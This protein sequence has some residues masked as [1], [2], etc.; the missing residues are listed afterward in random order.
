MVKQNSLARL[1]DGLPSFQEEGSR[2]P[3]ACG[4]FHSGVWWG[5]GQMWSLVTQ[6]QKAK[7]KVDPSWSLCLFL[8]NRSFFLRHESLKARKQ[9]PS[10]IPYWVRTALLVRPWSLF[11]CLIDT[12]RHS[13]SQ[14]TR[15]L[16]FIEKSDVALATVPYSLSCVR[17]NV[18]A[19]VHFPS[20]ASTCVT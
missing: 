15:F 20:R 7:S 1:G 4:C 9:C 18:I 10:A 2:S 11:L 3:P 14:E 13:P 19:A 12:V 16:N 5:C 6:P 8:P 17:D